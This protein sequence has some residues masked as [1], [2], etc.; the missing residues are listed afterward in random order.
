MTERDAPA[1]RP[2][3]SPARTPR[4]EAGREAASRPARVDAPA[5]RAGS[6]PTP[7][8]GPRASSRAAWIPKQH[9]AWAMLAVPFLVGVVR[10]GLAWPQ[11]PLGIAW[12]VGY[13]G[14]AAAGLWLRSRRRRAYLTP[15]LVYGGVS[16]LGGLAALAL[17]PGLL[18]WAPIYAP[19]A[20]VSLWFSARRADRALT[21]D[22]VT[23]VAASL[24]TLV[25]ASAGRLGS[26]AAAL[27]DGPLLG[28]T[29]ALAVYFVGTSLYVKTLIRERA[30]HGYKV[31]SIAYHATST[32][33]AASLPFLVPVS[34][35]PPAGVHVGLV[36]FFAV[37]TVRAAVLAG[38]RIR[39][40]KVGLGELAL[41]A[42]L[43][44]L[45]LL[46]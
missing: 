2:T 4:G 44:T 11:I 13:L 10:S 33:L 36:V 23:I 43:A 29:L 28:A 12:L 15:V 5:C 40:M 3:R 31:A 17:R 32:A 46:W 20:A 7:R 1:S 38:R 18:L 19:F 39:P 25:A 24:M 34:H 27:R 45:L 42:A 41:S 6:R 30:S 9:G 8:G 35:R 21:N 22:I 16:L 14:F 37:T 26:V